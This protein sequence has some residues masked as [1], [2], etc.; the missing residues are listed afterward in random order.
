VTAEEFWGHVQR[1][2]DAECWPWLGYKNANGYGWLHFA[3]RTQYA[4]RVAYQ[5]ATGQELAPEQIL[6]H[7]VCD[8]PA[9]VNPAHLAP[10]SQQD[11]RADCVAH[12]RQARGARN[13][14]AKL[15]LAAVRN[16][17]AWYAR[18]LATQRELARLFGVSPRAVR[19]VLSG[20]HWAADR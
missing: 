13:G 12:G 18:G 19:Y 4:H 6:R 1:G 9:C 8:N 17:R 11:N 20:Q 15:T 2:S 10:G 5:L 16:I 14:R 7:Y 3:G